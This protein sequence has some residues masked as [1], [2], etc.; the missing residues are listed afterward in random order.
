MS[1]RAH[2]RCPRRG[3]V[4]I[5][6]KRSSRLIRWGRR[7]GPRTR[8]MQLKRSCGL[9]KSCAEQRDCFG[10]DGGPPSSSQPQPGIQLGGGQHRRRITERAKGAKDDAKLPPVKVST[11]T[12]L[13]TERCSA[14]SA[15]SESFEACR[16]LAAHRDQAQQRGH[17]IVVCGRVDT[18]SALACDRSSG[19]VVDDCIACGSEGVARRGRDLTC[20][21]AS[22]DS[23]HPMR[24]ATRGGSFLRTAVCVSWQSG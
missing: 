10:G 8:H 18:E 24:D 12:V 21:T 23:P 11:P 16:S 19:A 3:E 14:Y 9:L 4:G 20:A 7:T 17:S 5:F 15:E 22:M 6:S 2:R 13:P 1:W